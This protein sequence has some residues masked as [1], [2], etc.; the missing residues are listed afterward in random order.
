[1][2]ENDFREPLKI[3]PG[4]AQN[5]AVTLGQLNTALAGVGAATGPALALTA[6]LGAT[7][8]PI[9]GH[10]PTG[11]IVINELKAS[12][13]TAYTGQVTFGPTA[14][15]ARFRVGGNLALAETFYWNNINGN[16]ISTSSLSAASVTS[17]E[18]E[19]WVTGTDLTI[20]LRNDASVTAAYGVTDYRI[21]VDDLLMPPSTGAVAT[22][23]DDWNH[24]PNSSAVRYHQL[25]FATART[26]RVRL[27]LGLVTLVQVRIPGTSDIWPAPPRFRGA[28]LGDSWGHASLGGTE[29]SIVAGTY[30]G[31]LAIRTG[32]EI[33]NLHQGGTGYENPGAGGGT[34]KYWSADRQA[35]LAALPAMDFIMVGGGGNDASDPPEEI[36]DLAEVMWR[37]IK[38]A[39]PTTPLIVIGAQAPNLFSGLDELNDALKARAAAIVDGAGNKVVD[40]FIDMWRGIHGEADPWITGTSGH[41]EDKDGNGSRDL[42]ITNE[43]IADIHPTHAGAR[44]IAERLAQRLRGAA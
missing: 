21:I 17:F 25:Q 38:A 11:D 33:W 10:Y 14:A 15:P 12:A 24:T 32:W 1:M 13:P 34:S 37:G 2:G 5:H 44:N 19:F 39:R 6:K 42:F 35:A 18:V 36:A 22:V 26:R 20:D 9:K 23:Q 41:I 40:L 31:E 3:T 4:T 7:M 43:A 16:D 30:P 29:G 27:M 8:S 28:S